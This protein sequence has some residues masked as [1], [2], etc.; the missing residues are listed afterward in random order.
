MKQIAVVIP[1]YDHAAYIGDAIRS[2]LAQTQ[3]VDKIVIVDDGSTDDSVEIVRA[4]AEPR[5][6]LY[7]QPNA[8]VHVALNRGIE[9][10]AGCDY[11]AILNSDDSQTQLGLGWR[12]SIHGSKA[13]SDRQRQSY[14]HCEKG[15]GS[16]RGC[17]SVENLELNRRGRSGYP[18]HE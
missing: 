3:R 13:S 11:V 4:F 5:I 6:E 9:N 2:V 14:R 1:L 8:G 7:T 18:R 17:G 16:R 15:G 10:A 12:K